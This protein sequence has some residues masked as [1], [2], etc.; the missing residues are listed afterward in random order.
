[1]RAHVEEIIDALGGRAIVCGLSMGAAIAAH[2]A[3][4][5]PKRARALVMVS[6]VGF[7]GVPGLSLVRGATPSFVTPYLPEFTGRWTIKLLLEVV[8]GKLRKITDRD[9]AEYEAPMQFPE[10]VIATRHLLHEFNWRVP[11][12]PLPVP[13]LMMTGGRDHLV[14]RKTAE[15]YCRIMPSL[16]NLV[17]QDAGHVVYDEAAPVVNDALLEFLE[18]AAEAA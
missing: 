18:A 1:M 12:K 11:F 7:S 4:S 14:S 3:H 2:V 8:N 6:P 10:F 9:V 13:S 17:I 15:S 5:S 16:R